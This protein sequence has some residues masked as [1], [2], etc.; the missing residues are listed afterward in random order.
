[1]EAF[2]LVRSAGQF[3]QFG[4]RLAAVLAEQFSVE[5]GLVV[6]IVLR[7]PLGEGSARLWKVSD[8]FRQLQYRFD[9]LTRGSHE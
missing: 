8:S 6:V 1:M 3:F 5:L 2:R 7:R 9:S 4:F